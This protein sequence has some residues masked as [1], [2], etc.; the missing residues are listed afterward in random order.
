VQTQRNLHHATSMRP[1]AP[2]VPCAA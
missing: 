2:S 1:T